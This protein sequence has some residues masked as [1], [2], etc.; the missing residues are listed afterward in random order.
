MRSWG[1]SESMNPRRATVDDD[2]DYDEGREEENVEL[3]S[4]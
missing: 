3:S 2:D 1:R 4:I